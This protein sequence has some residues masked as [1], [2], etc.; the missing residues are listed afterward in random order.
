MQPLQESEEA[1]SDELAEIRARHKED[2]EFW[3]GI[4]HEPFSIHN[5][6]GELLRLLDEATKREARLCSLLT[7]AA[8]YVELSANEAGGMEGFEAKR[9]LEEI[10]AA[11]SGVLPGTADEI[12]RLRKAL[13]FYADPETYFAVGFIGDPPCGEFVDDF[14]E[15]YEHEH[16]TG[17]RP[18][19]R[20]RAALSGAKP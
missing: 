1:M 8:T 5:H 2:S 6:R 9:H 11:L 14:D 20:A 13:K 3:K 19:K 15:A 7:H 10:R 18:G 16:M 4:G 12:E 17:P